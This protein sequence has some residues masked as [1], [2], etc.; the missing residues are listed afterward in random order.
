LGLVFILLITGFRR[1]LTGA[2]I[3]LVRRLRPAR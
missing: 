1:G 3:D 2:A